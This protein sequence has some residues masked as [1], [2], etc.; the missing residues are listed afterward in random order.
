M[1]MNSTSNCDM[2]VDPLVDVDNQNLPEAWM[3]RGNYEN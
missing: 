3:W 1:V 2:V